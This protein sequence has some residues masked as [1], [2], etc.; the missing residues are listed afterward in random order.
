MNV[1]ATFEWMN[2]WHQ[3]VLRIGSTAVALVD[4]GKIDERPGG[5]AHMND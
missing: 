1:K 3:K 4:N 2:G 5:V